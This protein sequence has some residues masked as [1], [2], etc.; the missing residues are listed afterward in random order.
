MPYKLFQSAYPPTR[1]LCLSVNAP[2][3]LHATAQ[4]KYKDS[5]MIFPFHPPLH[6]SHTQSVLLMTPPEDI[7]KWPTFLRALPC[8]SLTDQLWDKGPYFHSVQATP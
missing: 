8:Q 4:S 6:E 1:S 2:P 3:F 7:P 5:S